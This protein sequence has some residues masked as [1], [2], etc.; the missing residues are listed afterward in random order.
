MGLGK[1]LHKAQLRHN[2]ID[3]F[4]IIVVKDTCGKICGACY[5]SGCE[6]RDKED[7][8][9]NIVQLLPAAMTVVAASVAATTLVAAPR[10]Q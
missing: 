6:T 1:N 9:S 10:G 3:G 4:T 5:I 2:P 7:L 8:V